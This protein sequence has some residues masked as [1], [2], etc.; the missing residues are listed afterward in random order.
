M[1]DPSSSAFFATSEEARERFTEEARRRATSPI[2][3]QVIAIINGEEVSHSFECMAR[4]RESKM[5]SLGIHPDN[6][7]WALRS[8]KDGRWCEPI[9]TDDG[10]KQKLRQLR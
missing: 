3:Y 2:P 6:H 1:S 7:K 4:D 5:R 9:G 10:L 8:K